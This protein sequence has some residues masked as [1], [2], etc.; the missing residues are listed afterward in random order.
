MAVL[1]GK[2]TA[3]TGTI[4]NGSA[5]LLTFA[6]NKRYVI[7]SNQSGQKAYFVI[8]DVSG[9]QTVSASVYDFVLDD[10][11]TVM[12]DDVSVDTIGVFVAAASGIRAVGW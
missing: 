8:N 9:S 2:S 10:G 3:A 5:S 12:L 7:V 6:D 1:G 11:G 4:N